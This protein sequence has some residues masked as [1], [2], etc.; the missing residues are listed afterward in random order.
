VKTGE[1]SQ[2]KGLEFK[3]VIV[4]GCGDATFPSPGPSDEHTDELSE[5]KA[6]ELS[7]LF[8]A[9]TRARDFLT[10][11]AVDPVAP[12]VKSAVE[13]HGAVEV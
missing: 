11:V 7:H 10:L 13:E 4:A 12:E 1:W 9:M 5:R 2:A 6:L 8:V 3:A